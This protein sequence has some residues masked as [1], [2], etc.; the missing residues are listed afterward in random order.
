[1]KHPRDG[2]ATVDVMLGVNPLLSL[3]IRLPEE[4]LQPPERADHPDHSH[5]CTLH[6]LSDHQG[7]CPCKVRMVR[8]TE[9]VVI[10]MPTLICD[11]VL[12]H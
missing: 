6:V 1:M 3:L 12:A 9:T 5:H 7:V 10:L 2:S 11:S 4:G 8:Q